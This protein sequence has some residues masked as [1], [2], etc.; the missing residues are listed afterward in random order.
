[1]RG[2]NQGGREAGRS[3]NI[4]DRVQRQSQGNFLKDWLWGTIKGGTQDEHLEHSG[5]STLKVRAATSRKPSLNALP[6][7]CP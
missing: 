3:G 7:Q 2:L 1:M 5:L 4:L 6:T